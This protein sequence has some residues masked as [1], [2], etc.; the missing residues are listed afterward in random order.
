[1]QDSPNS[2][3]PPPSAGWRSTGH[4]PSEELSRQDSDVS[5]EHSSLS[6]RGESRVLH[7]VYWHQDMDS[8]EV[9]ELIR[10]RPI[11]ECQTVTSTFQ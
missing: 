6:R 3:S 8:D 10:W 2:L 11:H 5:R 4:L 7:R 9:E 1:M